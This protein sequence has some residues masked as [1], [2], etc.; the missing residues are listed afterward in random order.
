MS[1]KLFTIFITSIT[2][3][4][5]FCACILASNPSNKKE[6]V[7]PV[8]ERP[9]PQIT[10]IITHHQTM[11]EVLGEDEDSDEVD[12]E[13]YEVVSSNTTCS[14]SSSTPVIVENENPVEEIFIEES[15][16]EETPVSIESSWKSL[17]VYK[18]TA[19]CPCVKCCGKTN[20]ITASG[21]QATANRTIAASSSIPFGTQIK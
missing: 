2:S 9:K 10:A 13:T 11:E 15:V 12:I 20:G 18:V 4:I 16:E 17:G 3:A 19:Y 8:A 21:T 14:T 7:I 1:K 6:D 5:I